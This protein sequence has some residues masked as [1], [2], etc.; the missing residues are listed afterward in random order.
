ME[1]AV[2]F[3]GFHIH[4]STSL[5][6]VAMAGNGKITAKAGRKTMR[7]DYLIAGTGYRV[8]L[9]AQPEL[10][11]I[12][13]HVALWRDRFMP[14]KGEENAAGALHPYLGAGFEF[15]PRAATGA[16]FLRNIHCFNLAAAL[17]F[18][19]PVGDVPSMGL[20]PRLVTAISRDFTIGEVDVAA[21]QRFF[22]APLTAPDPAPY[23]KAVEGRARAAA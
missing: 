17:S 4:Q 19:V 23:E 16:E 11:R 12:H 9:A 6:D 1:R 2:A 15:Q 20:H 14:A 3:K 10:A 21:N 22:D 5:A 7:F 13:E 8:D 18:G